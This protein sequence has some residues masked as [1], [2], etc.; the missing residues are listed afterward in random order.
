MYFD[1][2]ANIGFDAKGT[3]K[4]FDFDLARVLPLG[5]DRLFQLTGKVGSP[6]YMAPEVK[7]ADKYNL[8]ADVFSFGV[9]VYEIY[10]HQKFDPPDTINWGKKNKKIPSNF[11]TELRMVLQQCLADINTDRPHMDKVRRMLKAEID[12]SGSDLSD[13]MEVTNLDQDSSFQDW[14]NTTPTSMLPKSPSFYFKKKTV[15]EDVS[16]QRTFETEEETAIF[17]D[18]LPFIGFSYP[19]NDTEQTVASANANPVVWV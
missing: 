8:T 2:L 16:S 12:Q 9:V 14:E 3:L 4:I 13:A 17:S 6:Q 15:L 5:R 11:S 1:D 19:C 7:R 18:S 10:T